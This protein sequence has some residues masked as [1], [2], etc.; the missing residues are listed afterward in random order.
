MLFEVFGIYRY[1]KY[2]IGIYFPAIISKYQTQNPIY[3][4][5][6][7]YEQI[8]R[9][10]DKRDK[11][12]K[13]VITSQCL[14]TQHIPLECLWSINRYLLKSI[15]PSIYQCGHPRSVPRI[16]AEGMQ[17]A[18]LLCAHG[19]LPLG[20]VTSPLLLFGRR[21]TSLTLFCRWFRP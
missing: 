2:F 17:C 1:R 20:D 14:A 21:S 4:L 16:H 13:I 10:T 8:Q 12:N 9:F 3:N 18:R 11:K 6:A 15:Q 5:W 19:S 7:A